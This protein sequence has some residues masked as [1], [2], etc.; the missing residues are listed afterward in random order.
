VQQGINDGKDAHANRKCKL[1]KWYDK[2][3]V[4]AEGSISCI[5]PKTTVHSAP[6]GYDCWRVWVERVIDPSVHLYRPTTEWQLLGP[7]E[8][9]TIAW[10][11]SCVKLI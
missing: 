5:D 1:L 6:L 7:T 10:P 11:K 2:M 3:E 8:G 4:V 9:S